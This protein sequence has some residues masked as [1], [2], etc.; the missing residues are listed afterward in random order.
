M[1]AQ[2]IVPRTRGDGRRAIVL[3]ICG[4]LLLVIG[5]VGLF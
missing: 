5:I 3:L 2:A 1:Q 4:A